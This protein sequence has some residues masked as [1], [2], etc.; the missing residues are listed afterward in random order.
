MLNNYTGFYMIHPLL[1]PMKILNEKEKKEVYEF[2][3]HYQSI[4]PIIY[5]DDWICKELGAKINDII[6]IQDIKSRLYRLVV[7]R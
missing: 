6:C 5:E 7:S 4:L 1:K 3:N 2:F